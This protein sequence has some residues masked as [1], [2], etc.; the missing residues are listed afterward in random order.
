MKTILEYIAQLSD[1]SESHTRP[2]RAMAQCIRS[3]YGACAVAIVT[4]NGLAKGRW[5]LTG[6]YTHDG[7][8]EVEANELFSYNS[9][10][11]THA[12]GVLEGLS[13]QPDSLPQV[14]A[15]P[16][17][18]L[19]GDLRLHP[20]CNV[21]VIPLYIDGLAC[22]WMLLLGASP[23]S[24][25]SID[26]DYAVLVANL[27]A[28][29]VARVNDTRKLREAH[30]WI[31]KELREI[32]DLQTLLL[33]NED[34]RFRG[35]Q[36]AVYF[37]AFGQAGGDYY[38]LVHLDPFLDSGSVPADSEPEVWGVIVAD[39]S[40]HGAVAAVE[41]AMFDAILRTYQGSLEDG[42]AAVL[43]YANRYFFTRRL[44]GN[45]ITALL[46]NYDPRSR[47]LTYASAGHPGPLIRR[48]QGTGIER[49]EDSQ[50][51]P[52][53]VEPETSWQN[54]HI[55][56]Y[57]GDLMVLYTDGVSE[58]RNEY[59]EVL[60][61]ERLERWILAGPKEPKALLDDLKL[62]LSR[63]SGPEGRQDDQTLMVILIEE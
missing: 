61:V 42:P 53:G 2:F 56:L 40:G 14:R 52:L 11:P 21:L 63:F 12:Y 24:L 30:D 32:A 22:N 3:R 37:K 58:L 19:D 8:M 34:T 16:Q 5:Q 60:G 27:A 20:Y 25:R 44:R 59:D 9:D 51:V 6:L 54:L 62:R 1:T 47:I 23:D 10:Q 28:T 36:V 39:V 46:A 57:P 29:C 17:H 13:N 4:Q 7:K 43:A 33:P 48:H 50:G 26:V 49:H 15:L 18:T 41:A 31:E 38:D 55:P 35:A 45:F